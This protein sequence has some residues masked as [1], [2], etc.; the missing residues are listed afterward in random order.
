MLRM[1]PELLWVVPN[2]VPKRRLRECYP[3]P[4]F[5]ATRSAA[6]G[7]GQYPKYDRTAMRTVVI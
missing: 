7:E 3:R 5:P 6:A 2:V 4:P 1:F